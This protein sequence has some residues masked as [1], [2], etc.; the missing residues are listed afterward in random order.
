MSRIG[1]IGRRLFGAAVLCALGVGAGAALPVPAE[2][3]WPY[4]CDSQE[5]HDGCVGNGA[6]YGYCN[7]YDDSCECVW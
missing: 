4:A 3:R 1:K 7:Y 5:C 6:Q 2:A